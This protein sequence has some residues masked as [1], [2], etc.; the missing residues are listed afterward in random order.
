MNNAVQTP[1]P[2]AFVLT[3]SGRPLAV[4]TN[5]D[6]AEQDM[7]ICNEAQIRENGGYSDSPHT[8]EIMVCEFVEIK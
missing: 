3:E 8:Y 4:Y 1:A 7:N 6:L 5:P 2:T